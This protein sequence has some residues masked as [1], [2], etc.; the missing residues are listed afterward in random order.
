MGGKGM[1]PPRITATFEIVTPMFLGGAEHEASRIRGSAIKGALAFWWRAYNFARFVKE[2][3][4]DH[5]A[6]LEAMHEREK[7]LFGS[8]DGGQ[9]SFLLKVLPGKLTIIK[10]ENHAILKNENGGLKGSVVGIGARY[11]GYGM[12]N[13]FHIKAKQNR[14][15]KKEGELERSCFAAD[16]DGGRNTFSVQI[17]FRSKAT[18]Y[19]ID[20]IVHALKLFGL[21]GGL[22]SRV[23]RGWGSVVLTK[24]EF[25]GI[26]GQEDWQPPA[27]REAYSEVLQELF[28]DHPL[29]ELSGKDWLLTAFASESA[30]WSGNSLHI[31][32]L[33]CLDALG[34]AILNYRA[35][36]R[37]GATQVGGQ[38]ILRQFKEDHDW[39]RLGSKS[40][41][42]PYRTAFGLPHMYD[43]KKGHGV[44]PS[45]ESERRASPI[46]MHIHKAGNS[47]FPVITYLPTKFLDVDVQAARPLGS[48]TTPYDFFALS[49]RRSASGEDV[50]KDFVGKGR[51]IFKANVVMKF[52]DV[53]P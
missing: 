39:F 15:E 47:Y 43:S 10:A 21:V 40:V 2:A 3:G 7:E 8:S 5:E 48:V 50:I 19:D 26:E 23:R 13:A 17:A 37:G 4:G 29:R 27:S 30:I 52:D 12:L 41:D 6:A 42:I 22:G 1:S 51:G 16:V 11:L 44:V 36:G 38:S 24:L 45:G 34:R 33:D 9:G 35:M 32:G 28:K 18:S 46:L 20:E 14:P 25:S 31:N 53:L 49:G